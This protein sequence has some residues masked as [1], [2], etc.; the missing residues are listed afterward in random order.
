MPKAG[1][2]PN[3]RGPAPRH[4]TWYDCPWE[5]EHLRWTSP[6]P[7]PAVGPVLW[8]FRGAKPESP[9]QA[10][11][12]RGAP[13]CIQRVL[14]RSGNPL[15]AHRRLRRAHEPHAA[16]RVL[17]DRR[18]DHLV[19]RAGG[20]PARPGSLPRLPQPRAQPRGY[21]LKGRT[22]AQA[23][24]EA[25]GIKELPPVVPAEEEGAMPGA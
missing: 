13:R 15:A 18:A 12:A 8:I 2:P 10:H 19:S 3:H 21:R 14:P 11:L 5:L 6:E 23:L 16:G 7:V 17:P 25:L 4:R 9:R 20:D 1:D 22:P 24:R